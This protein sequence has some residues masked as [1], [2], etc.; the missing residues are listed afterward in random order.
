MSF[1]V[2]GIDLPEDAGSLDLVVYDKK[3]NYLTDYEILLTEAIQI[4]TPHGRLIDADALEYKL[5]ASDEDIYVRG[6]LEEDAPTRL[7]AE[8]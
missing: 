3:G 6:V 8:E 4:P 2:K 5:G 1:I 7:E